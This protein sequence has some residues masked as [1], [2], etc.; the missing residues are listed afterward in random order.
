MKIKE[1]I[2]PFGTVL[3]LPDKVYNDFIKKHKALIKKQPKDYYLQNGKEIV[4]L[5]F[6]IKSP[7]EIVREIYGIRTF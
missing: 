1:F 7:E 3:Y 6:P 4:T 2:T 5:W